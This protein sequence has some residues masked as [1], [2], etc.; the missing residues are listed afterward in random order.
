MADALRLAAPERFILP[1]LEHGAKCSPLLTL[2]LQ[3][4]SLTR[5]AQSFIREILRLCGQDGKSASIP[6]NELDALSMAASI[7]AREQGLLNLMSRGCSNREMAEK[8][9]ISESTVKTHLGNIYYKLSVNSRVLAVARAK[10]LKL[11]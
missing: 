6:Q 8:L 7:S 1:F 2:V 10:E 3:T 11:V 5:E 9:C 4:E